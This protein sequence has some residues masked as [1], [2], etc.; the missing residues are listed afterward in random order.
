MN[1]KD[2]PNQIK[3]V[4]FMQ[5]WKSQILKIFNNFYVRKNLNN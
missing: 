3:P 2:N 5:F 1:W 4:S